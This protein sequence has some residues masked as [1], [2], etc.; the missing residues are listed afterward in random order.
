MNDH[1]WIT[2]DAEGRRVVEE[3]TA[4]QSLVDLSALALFQSLEGKAAQGELPSA[5][6]VAA[7]HE[8]IAALPPLRAAHWAQEAQ[9]VGAAAP[10]KKTKPVATKAADVTE[11]EKPKTEATK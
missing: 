8:T 11:D 4:E 2:Q 7:F 10:Q 3:L 6:D 9:R 5:A 1:S